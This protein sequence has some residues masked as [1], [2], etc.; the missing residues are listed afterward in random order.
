MRLV[1]WLILALLVAAARAAAGR[2]FYKVR[3]AAGGTT[4]AVG[5]LPWG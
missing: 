2:D 1:R 3:Y 4:L 5:A